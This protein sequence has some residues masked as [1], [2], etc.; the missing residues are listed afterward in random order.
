MKFLICSSTD[1]ILVEFVIGSIV[2]V[3]TSELLTN[4]N[5]GNMLSFLFVFPLTPFIRI[6]EIFLSFFLTFCL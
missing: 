5:V 1:V 4:S 3:S 2:A 6:A